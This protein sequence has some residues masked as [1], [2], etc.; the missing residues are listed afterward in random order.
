LKKRTIIP[1]TIFGIFLIGFFFITPKES[2]NNLDNNDGLLTLKQKDIIFNQLKQFPDKT[3]MA[4]SF[5]RSDSS[6]FYGAIKQND[7]VFEIDNKFS[8]FEIG[9]ITKVFTTTLLADFILDSILSLNRDI[10]DD[11]DFKLNDDIHISYKELANHTSG[12]P[13]R[14]SDLIFS[15]IKSPLNPYSFYNTDKLKKNLKDKLSLNSEAGTNYEYSNLGFGILG[16]VLCKVAQTDYETLLREK[17]FIKY[18]L[19][20]TT[21]IKGKTSDKLIAGIGPFGNKTP[22]WDFASLEACGNLISSTNDLSRFVQAQFDTN[23]TELILTRESTFIIKD[24]KE[25][26]L[27]WHILKD[28]SD[29]DWYFHNGGTGGYR[30]SVVFDTDNKTG[31]IILTNISVGN[32]KSKQVDKLCFALMTSNNAR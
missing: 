14:P 24:T 32:R 11:L 2:I 12:L 6:I 3:Q 29:N 17:I 18:G 23:N 15:T 10:N 8:L 19:T 31:I 28:K 27:G 21:S 22:N 7:T 9:S 30:S 16:N 20:N 26:G 1:I 25:V 5:I 4:I 13:R